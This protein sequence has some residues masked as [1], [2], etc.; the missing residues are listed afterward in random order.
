MIGPPSRGKDS[1]T[2]S[3]ISLIE[4]IFSWPL[5]RLPNIFR[6]IERL[7]CCFQNLLKNASNSQRE[8]H[9]KQGTVWEVR[10][11][12]LLSK[13]GLRHRKCA[14]H[15]ILS[16]PNISIFFFL[17]FFYFSC[18]HNLSE[19]FLFLVLLVFPSSLSKICHT[20]MV[21]HIK[22]EHFL[23]IFSKPL[24][25]IFSPISC[26]I[27]LVHAHLAAENE[28]FI[29][30]HTWNSVGT[31]YSAQ[32]DTWNRIHNRLQQKCLYKAHL[33]GVRSRHSLSIMNSSSS[34]KN[35]CY[36]MPKCSVTSFEC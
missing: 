1:Y 23:Q 14:L 36:E 32:K 13:A 2:E 18:R 12:I 29:V 6:T 4:K 17:L 15:R 11:S 7:G 22:C 25:L 31:L 21:L 34:I 8:I 16:L 5:H 27:S 9:P 24:S 28:R 10:W 26:F 33:I 3:V 19:L 30:C 20:V 35:A